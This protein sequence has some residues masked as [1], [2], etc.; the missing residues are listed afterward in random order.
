MT[1]TATRA[2]THRA[3]FCQLATLLIVPTFADQPALSEKDSLA[4][5]FESKGA[6]EGTEGGE[7]NCVA[8]K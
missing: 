1:A 2:S 6:T 5:S 7:I 8:P 3:S 4:E